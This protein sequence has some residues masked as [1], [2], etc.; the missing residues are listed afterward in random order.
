MALC[1]CGKPAEEL[2]QKLAVQ[3]IQRRGFRG[4]GAFIRGGIQGRY[5]T[6]GAAAR[7][8]LSDSETAEKKPSDCIYEI[9]S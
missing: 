5:G 2:L 3:G 7:A 9:L 6:G 1:Y 4:V 8:G